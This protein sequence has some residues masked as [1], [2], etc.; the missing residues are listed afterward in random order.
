MSILAFLNVD[1]SRLDPAGE[2][3]SGDLDATAL[4]V[5]LGDGLVEPAG[6]VQ[7]DLH[8]ER[9]GE[10]LLVRGTAGLD[11]NCVCSRCSEKFQLRVADNTFVNVYPLEETSDFVD[12][13]PDLREA[14]ILALP[15]YPVCRETCRGFCPRCGVNL[16][17]ASCRCKAEGTDG[18]WGALNALP[19]SQVRARERDGAQVGKDVGTGAGKKQ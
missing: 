12:L 17:H 18:R 11:V 1:I 16:N 13:T 4:D 2:Q 15:R 14:I 8:V 9:I 19:L 3:M 5:S 10:E 6:P 7:Y